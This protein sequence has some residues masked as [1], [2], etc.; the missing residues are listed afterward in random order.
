VVTALSIFFLAGAAIAFLSAGALFFPGSVLEPMWDINPRAREAFESMGLW[1]VALMAA[2]GLACGSSAIG[3]WKGTRWGHW[4]ALDLLGV[5]LV[6]D[7][8]NAL[9][10]TEPRAALG[11]PIASAIIAYLTTKRV[12]RFFRPPTS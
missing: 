11:V 10:G 8:L 12:R 6:A 4:L 9:L 7:A 1:A 2:V 5:N 3:L